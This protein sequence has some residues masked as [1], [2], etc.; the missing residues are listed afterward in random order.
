MTVRKL[1]Y[2]TSFRKYNGA[3]GMKHGKSYLR[4][5]IVLRGGLI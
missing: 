3:W 5:V 4:L 2:F 1:K